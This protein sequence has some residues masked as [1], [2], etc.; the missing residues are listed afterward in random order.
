MRNGRVTPEGISGEG[1]HVF[2]SF[3]GLWTIGS[4]GLFLVFVVTFFV[5]GVFVTRVFVARVVVSLRKK[6]EDDDA[7]DQL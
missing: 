1:R 7:K 3:Q 6:A 2:V 5:T 4:P